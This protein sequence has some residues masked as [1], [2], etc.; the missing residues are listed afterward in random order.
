[1]AGTA[2]K[3]SGRSSKHSATGAKTSK[4]PYR[5]PTMVEIGEIRETNGLNVV[6]TFSGCGGSC[7]GFEMA[8]Y[9]IAWASEFVA[10][11]RDSYRLNHDGVHLDD[12][13]IR[14]VTADD[15][16]R[17]TGGIEIDVLEG[18]PPCAA[19]S[20]A[21]IGKDGWGKIKQYS[22]RRQRVDDLFFE[23][24]RLVR[25][26]QPR[27]FVAENVAGLV[28]GQAK[29]YF[30]LIM[31]ELKDCGYTVSAQL[32]N[33]RWLGVPQDRK[34]IIICDVRNDIGTEP[35][36]PKPLSYSYSINEAIG[37]L[38]D[39]QILEVGVGRGKVQ[40]ADQPSPTI[41]T[42]GNLYT[43]SERSV[44]VEGDGPSLEGYAVGREWRT[45]REG[46]SSKKYFNL[47]RPRG[48][49]PSPTVT[50]LGGSNPGVASVTH[51]TEFRKFTIAELRRICGFPDDFQLIGTFAQQWERLG[52][53]VPPVM[54]SHMAEALKGVLE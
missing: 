49:K 13:D 9:R 12:R 53:A 28:R 2:K 25:E 38:V 11:A 6:S 8:G 24:A 51:P 7:L 23:Y 39:G 18:S 48:D 26:L 36:Y 46:E 5:V 47:V 50:Q 21:G 40:S 41:M 37:D 17:A 44:L 43:R 30:K 27:T 34:R 31:R 35:I 22:E 4:P 10:A 14:E 19:F 45:L 29:G 32:L 42:H 20:T 54:M 33:A 1:M 52:R 16:R 3:R 15:I